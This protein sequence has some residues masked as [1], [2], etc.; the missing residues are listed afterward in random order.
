V[1]YEVRSTWS[2]QDVTC[3]SSIPVVSEANEILYCVGHRKGEGF[4]LEALDWNTGEQVFY[5]TMGVLYNPFGAG[6]EI[7]KNRD[8]IAG[9]LL[10]P[11]RVTDADI[12]EKDTVEGLD[13]AVDAIE[14][15]MSGKMNWVQF[16]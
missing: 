2:R 3:A 8:V 6:I 15:L 1:T 7:G 13:D 10:G 14:M 5:K 4:T 16:L 11:V 9:S 12:V